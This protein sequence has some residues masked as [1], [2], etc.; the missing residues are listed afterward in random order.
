MSDEKDNPLALPDG[1]VDALGSIDGI[2]APIK[3]SFF[4]ALGSLIAGLA[5]VPTAWL[6]G[7]AARIRTRTQ[8]HQ[9]VMTAAAKAAAL[10]AAE[11]PALVNRAL[12]Y[13]ANQLVREQAN[14]E[15][16]AQHASEA[17]RLAAPKLEADQTTGDTTN[18][19]VDDEW[20]SQF[21]EIAAKKSKEEVQAILGR[22]LA[23]EVIKPGSFA[24]ITLEVLSC[25]DRETAQLFEKTCNWA[26]GVEP[27]RWPVVVIDGLDADGKRSINDSTFFHL[28]T[29]GLMSSVYQKQLNV[30]YFRDRTTT[31]GG[32]KL[33][34]SKCER[35]ES[36]KFLKGPSIAEF[37]LA[38]SQ[39]YHVIPPTFDRQYAKYLRDGLARWGLALTFPDLSPGL[40]SEEATT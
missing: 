5:D 7:Q 34:I 38:G 24:P 2:P 16:V 14:R 36:M 10:K 18:H 33:M 9:A 32:Q 1:V 28:Q 25:L 4:K 26:L 19:Q 13:H 3:Q 37:S 8:G 15:A 20:L 11:D 21:R 17:I 23:G 30:E 12:E 31:L 35:V 22:I 27:N 40:E 39:L 29:Y 6:E